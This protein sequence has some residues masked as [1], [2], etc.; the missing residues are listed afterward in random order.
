M[1]FHPKATHNFLG[2][3]LL[4]RQV[5]HLASTMSEKHS[6]ARTCVRAEDEG[7]RHPLRLFDQVVQSNEL[8]EALMVAFSS[9]SALDSA[10]LD[11]LL[12]Q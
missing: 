9:A 10:T 2:P 6:L 1:Y 11:W 8:A 12:D 4:Y 7:H 3:K 5:L